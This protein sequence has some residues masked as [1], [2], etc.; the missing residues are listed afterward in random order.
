MSAPGILRGIEN[1]STELFMSS[2]GP[3]ATGGRGGTSETPPPETDVLGGN[4]GIAGIVD[5]TGLKSLE[6]IRRSRLLN[7]RSSSF[8][9][10]SRRSTRPTTSSRANVA[11]PVENEVDVPNP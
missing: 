6:F 8:N 10:R 4:G 1:G 9:L 11:L 5:G 2:D 7:R 3:A